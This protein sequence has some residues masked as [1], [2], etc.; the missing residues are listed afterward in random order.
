MSVLCRKVPNSQTRAKL[1]ARQKVNL[2]SSCR[3]LIM[4][5]SPKRQQQ[6]S[7]ENMTIL[8]YETDAFKFSWW[9]HAWLSAWDKEVLSP[10][11]LEPLKSYQYKGMEL[12][13]IAKYILT[14]YWNA[15]VTWCVPERMAPNLVTFI[16]CLIM[17]SIGPVLY[18]WGLTSP[19]A[20]LSNSTI[21]GLLDNNWWVWVY[22]AVAFWIYSTCDA[23][24]GKQA[25]RTGS[26]SPLGEL[27]DHGCDALDVT[28]VI[29]MSGITGGLDLI[30]TPSK[31]DSSAS[32]LPPV[33]FYW[34]TAFASWALF[35]GSTWEV[36]RTGVL[37]LG[38]V[39]GVTEGS[40]LLVL[41]LLMRAF[42]GLAFWQSPSPISVPLNGSQWLRLTW[43]QLASVLQATSTV[44]FL[45]NSAYNV[46]A[47]ESKQKTTPKSTLKKH[48]MLKEL[49]LPVAMFA[50]GAWLLLA[51][52]SS[53][54]Y[55]PRTHPFFFTC[56]CGLIHAKLATRLILA[57][58]T[59]SQAYPVHTSLSLWALIAFG[60]LVRLNMMGDLGQRVFLAFFTTLYTLGYVTFLVQVVKNVSR[61]LGI[62]VFHL[63]PKKLAK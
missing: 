19:E 58:L 21:T 55:Y 10:S 36:Y 9:S 25:K 33:N 46:Y 30:T 5:S 54:V 43:A 50:V 8:A 7:N 49:V 18:F 52:P 2:F 42:L 37:I 24:D 62:R 60:F 57:H 17:M 44:I 31:S 41:V 3:I 20:S 28:L 14:P 35:Y 61:F 38:Y 12:S 34:I 26:G 51:S 53:I 23:V 15:V 39:N 47:H 59:H 40:L 32:F 45:A 22:A 16:G 56:L 48:S 1:C 11:S 63:P 29:L 4:G 27:F 13:P 6:T